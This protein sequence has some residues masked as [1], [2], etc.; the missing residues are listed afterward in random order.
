MDILKKLGL[1]DSEIET[2]KS[3][4]EEEKTAIIDGVKISIEE[5]VNNNPER[6]KEIVDKTKLETTK[7]I[8][9]K[10]AKTLGVQIDSKEDNIDTILEKGKKSLIS[11]SELTAQDLQTKVVELQSKITEYDSAII[12]S[13]RL[14]EQSKVNQVYIDM[15]LNSSA[16]K[17]D[18]S[19]L[20]IEDRILIGRNKIESM[21][22]KLDYDAEKKSV[23]IKHKE[24]G[25]KPQF[26]EKTY[27][28][29]DLDGVL[30]A[31]L[32]PYVPKSNGGSQPPVGQNTS[33]GATIIAGVE[34]NAV[35]QRMLNEIKKP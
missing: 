10:I 11:N 31:V 18:K 14:E 23:I 2:L 8:E 13:I 22:L 7:I 15:A 17:L 20:P 9:K 33:G 12:P 30:G 26:G 16:S 28:V 32:E 27:D 1:T 5:N 3:G 24:T 19:I 4:T 29:T 21:G 25:L 35:A 34:V 6:Y